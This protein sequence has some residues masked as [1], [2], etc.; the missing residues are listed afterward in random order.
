MFAW[1]AGVPVVLIDSYG[2]APDRFGYLMLT[3]TLG[4]FFGYASAIWLTGKLGVNRMIVLGTFIGLLGAALYLALPLAGVLTPL[5]AIAPMSLFGIGLAIAFPSVM[6]A[7]VSVRPDYAGTAASIN[8]LVQYGTAAMATL[9][10]GALSSTT[11]LPLA[12][13]IFGTQSLAMIAAWV[14]WRGRPAE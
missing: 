7:A 8:G 1:F 3:G 9:L 13:V 11:H 14:G 10:V 2:I 5:A 4:A 12:W 6:A